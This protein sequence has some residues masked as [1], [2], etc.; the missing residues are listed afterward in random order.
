MYPAL[1][2]SEILRNEQTEILWVGSQG[3]ME[4]NLVKRAG[5][6]F[7]AIPAAGVHGVS[8]RKLPGNVI[9]LWKG[10]WQSRK[11]LKNFQPDVLFF[12]GGYVAIPMAL[13]G[14]PRQSLCYVP[15]IEPGLALKTLTRW[16]DHIALSVEDSRRYFKR[17]EKITVTGYPIRS[18]LASW[19]KEKG[20][21]YFGFSAATPTVLFLGGSSG[22]RSINTAVLANAEALTADYQVIHIS[23]H[24]D[25]DSI[26]QKTRNLS[27]RYQAFPYLHEIGAAFAAADLVVSR[28]GAS[29]LGEYPAFGLPA[30]LVPY[31]YAWRYQKTNADFLTARG[32]AILLEDQKLQT[33]LLTT[34]QGLLM[35]PDRLKRMSSAM[36]ALSQP[37]AAERIGA[38][39][40]NLAEG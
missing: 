23:G 1:T 8:L 11:I 16:S 10:Y 3:G 22:A 14:L 33:D 36:K 29:I 7:E 26:Q 31:P 9:R 4:E 30:V 13:A 35:D 19:T 37:Q 15:D 28:S 12:T 17:Q 32:A 25:W 39:L 6:Q 18:D 27:A 21:E 20:L 5:L 34:V 40:L 2:V 24:L 38:L